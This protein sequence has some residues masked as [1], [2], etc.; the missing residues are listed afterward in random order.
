MI[1]TFALREIAVHHGQLAAILELE[2]GANHATLRLLVIARKAACDGYGLLLAEQGN[3]I[4][5]FLTVEVDVITHGLDIGARK[6]IVMHLD[7]LQ[8]YDI[9]VVGVDECLQLRQSCAQSIDIKRYY[10]HEFSLVG[11][12]IRLLV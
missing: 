12:V 4:V 5:R 1:P 9:G 6:G 7:L 10:F 3:P 2:A 8:P 11:S